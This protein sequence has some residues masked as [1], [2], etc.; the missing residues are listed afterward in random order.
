MTIQKYKFLQR[1]K[2]YNEGFF[3]S[4]VNAVSNFIVPA[5]RGIISVL[6]WSGLC[7]FLVAALKI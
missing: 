7:A 3:K 1:E 4:H 6:C 5:S 2:K